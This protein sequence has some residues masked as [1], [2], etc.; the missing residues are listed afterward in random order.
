MPNVP[1]PPASPQ[2]VS[3]AVDWDAFVVTLVFDRAI[4]L[5]GCVTNTISVRDGE[6]IHGVYRGVGTATPIGDDG[7][8]IAL[9]PWLPYEGSGTFLTAQTDTGIVASDG[10]AEWEGEGLLPLPFP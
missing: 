2:L 10:G 3:A 9:E 1:P 5:S 8:S 4:D 6:T 7:V